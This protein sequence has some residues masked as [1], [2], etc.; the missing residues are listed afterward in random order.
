MLFIYSKLFALSFSPGSVDAKAHV[1]VIKLIRPIGPVS[2]CHNSQAIEQAGA[3][4]A[5]CSSP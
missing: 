1:N 3:G 2:V 5:A 4:S